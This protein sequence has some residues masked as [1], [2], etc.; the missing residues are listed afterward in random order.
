[1]EISPTFKTASVY[2]TPLLSFPS[3]H[4]DTGVDSLANPTYAYNQDFSNSADFTRNADAHFEVHTFNTTNIPGAAGFQI[5]QVDINITFSADLG[6]V[7]TYRIYYLVGATPGAADLV[8]VTVA[9]APLANYTW[10]DR[11]EPV[12]GTWSTADISS[13]IVRFECDVSKK[14]EG[15]WVHVYDVRITLHI[16]FKFTI[17]VDINDV[18]GLGGYEFKL[19]YNTSVLT[20]TGITYNDDAGFFYNHFTWTE[21]IND[22]GGWLWLVIS[23]PIGSTTP[24]SGSG[25]ICTIDF[26]MDGTSG[27]SLLDLYDTKLGELLTPTPIDHQTYDGHFSSPAATANNPVAAFAYLPALPAVDESIEFNATTSYAQSPE[28]LI[29]KYIWDFD[30]ANITTIYDPLG[31][32]PAINHSY[33]A[34]ATYTVNLTVVDRYNLRT[35]ITQTVTVSAGVPE[36]P[37]GLALEIGLAGVIIFVWWRSRKP[38]LPH[39]KTLVSH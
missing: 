1:M 31:A 28:P 9:S 23:L 22:P 39:R 18:T 10:T 26:E 4:T 19:G 29:I 16:D 32:E 21:Q 11:P 15:A 38:K 30:D 8:G 34:G 37:V 6:T 2:S 33:A 7:D 27:L 36:F 12:D 24:V 25:T 13:L 14:G 20:A 3:A 35:W 5:S 17:D